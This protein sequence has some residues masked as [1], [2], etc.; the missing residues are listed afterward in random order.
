VI[1]GF[2]APRGSRKYFGALLFAVCEKRLEIC[3]P[4]RHRLRH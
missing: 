4:R 2:T 1:I 3:G